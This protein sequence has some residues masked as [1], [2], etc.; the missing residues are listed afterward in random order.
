MRQ[1]SWNI[2]TAEPAGHHARV[3]ARWF[4]ADGKPTGLP[5]M[6]LSDRGAF[7]THI[8]LPDDRPGK[9]QLLAAV[10]GHLAPPLWEKMT[11]AEMERMGQVGHLGTWDDIVEFVTAAKCAPALAP[12]NSAGK[13]REKAAV[14]LAKK[15]YPEA[16]EAAR[17]ARKLLAEAYLRAQPSPK[18]EGRAIWNHSGTGA[19]P[20]DWERTARELQAAGFNMVLPNMLWGGVAH[21][22]SDVLP[23][24]KTF[25][26]HGD[27]IAQCVAA[28]HRHGIEVH[29]WKVNWNL[30]RAPKEFVEKMQKAGRTQV[31]AAGKPHRWLCPSHPENFKL[32]LESMLEV[33]RK[34]D[35]DGLHFDYI[36]Y[37]GGQCCYCEGCRARFEADRKAKVA[38]W[39]KDCYSGPLKEE[40]RTWR[41]RQITR[42]VE[43]V[44]RE[45]KRLKPEIKISAAVFGSYPACR[46]SVGQDWAEWIKAGYLDFVCPMDYTQSDMAF[47][48]LVS[49][50]LKL[51][52]GRIPLYPGIG[53]WRLPP[54]RTVGQIYHA[55]RLGAAG[56]TIFN[57]SESAIQLHVP[58]IGLGAGSQKAVPPHRK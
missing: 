15:H 39:P 14:E 25:E 29:V 40:Y 2:T 32:E 8:I 45:V 33:A 23:R 49:S 50:Q 57:L 35:V 11:R 5:A 31:T 26:E 46:E 18:T 22:A 9:K 48:N 17:R 44:R 28:C 54:D 12:L 6:L 7:L 58:A 30:S 37:P 42:L 24:S 36:R 27:Q 38:H 21:Y 56:F 52:G 34:Y 19:Y 53:A 43:A 41:C 16:V 51:V 13:A 55:R 3:I 4:D 1:A 20:G 10:L 47:E